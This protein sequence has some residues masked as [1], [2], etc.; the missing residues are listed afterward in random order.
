MPGGM[1]QEGADVTA[2]MGLGSVT[3]TRPGVRARSSPG[4]RVPEEA[5]ADAP[6]AAAGVAMPSLL[7]LQEAETDAVRDREARRHCGGLLAA[8][9]AVQ[10]RLLD[11]AE[12][13]GLEGLAAL[14]RHAPAP[15]D[16]RLA[17]V[18]R[19]LLQRAAV[20]LARIGARA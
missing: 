12:A 6:M 5:R 18:Q 17:A 8:L 20:E 1:K 2:I 11:G 14:L 15:S 16:P 13:A 9:A 19:A 10:L 7:A 4:F 3:G